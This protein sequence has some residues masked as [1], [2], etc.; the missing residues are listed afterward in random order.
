MIGR[1]FPTN[2]RP[3][4]DPAAPSLVPGGPAAIRFS[5]VILSFFASG[6][7]DHTL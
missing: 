3:D 7:R 6:Q 5:E 4:C 1:T 2:G